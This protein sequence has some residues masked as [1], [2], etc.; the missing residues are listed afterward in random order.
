M[1]L[2]RE[3]PCL[4]CQPRS[5]IR[6]VQ[7]LIERCLILRMARDDCVQAL[8]RHAGIEPLVTLTG[9][10]S[11][12]FPAMPVTS[13]LLWNELMKANKEFFQ[14]YNSESS[15]TCRPLNMESRFRQRRQWSGK[16]NEDDGPWKGS[17]RMGR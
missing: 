4:C 2:G 13:D 12:P 11:L 15:P 10:P 14:T 1:C 3:Q 9:D 7:H 17:P 6:M 8:A 16:L 5:Y